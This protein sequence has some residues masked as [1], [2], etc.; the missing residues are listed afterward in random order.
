MKIQRHKPVLIGCMKKLKLARMSLV[1]GTTL[2]LAS[3]QIGG[4]TTGYNH[5]TPAQKARIEKLTGRIAD[6]KNDDGKVYK[7]TVAQ[8]KDFICGEKDVVVYEFIPYCKAEGCI[9]PVL[10]ERSC[11]EKNYR[12]VVV[13]VLYDELFSVK[14]PGIPM[15]SIDT[16]PYQTKWRRKYERCFFDEL[17]GITEKERSYYSFHYFHDGKYVKS[18]HRFNEVP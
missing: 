14:H 18:Y 1:L 16:E 15:F 7:I 13:A 4:L 2:L 10:F 11:R 6:V 3:C 12:A 8:L 17:T 5:L 9:P